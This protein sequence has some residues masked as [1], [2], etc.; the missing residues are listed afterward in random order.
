MRLHSRLIWM[1]EVGKKTDGVCQA[2]DASKK[3]GNF[4]VAAK[5]TS[6]ARTREEANH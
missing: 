3:G 5:R 6:L 4:E 2:L 1:T